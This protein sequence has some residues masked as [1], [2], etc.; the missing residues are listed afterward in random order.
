MVGSEDFAIG[1]FQNIFITQGDLHNCF[2]HGSFNAKPGNIWFI[3]VKRDKEDIRKV[4]LKGYPNAENF[5]PHGMY[6]SN[7]TDLLYVIN[8]VQTYSGVEIFKI[9]YT[10]SPHSITLSHQHTLRSDLFLPYAPNDVVEG[11]EKGE[12]YVTMW[13]PFGYPHE[14]KKHPTN[15]GQRIK[16]NLMM[17]LNVFGIKMTNVYHCTWGKDGVNGNKCFIA[18]G[19]QRYGMANGISINTERTN[20]FINDVTFKAIHTY[21]IN[22]V[23]GSLSQ[24]E[25]I[26]LDYPADNIE[27]TGNGD[28]ILGTMPHMYKLAMNDLRAGIYPAVPGGVSLISRRNNGTYSTRHVIMHKGDKLSQISAATLWGETIYL[29]S[30]FDSGVLMCKSPQ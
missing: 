23:D 14:G 11:R 4:N 8:H 28:L 9:D 25:K 20:L 17:P 1:K 22:P 29:G 24:L 3:N 7:K 12:L 10:E 21:A 5:H 19:S 27:F 2:N 13:L 15:M 16:K 18:K 26:P 30:P 6:I